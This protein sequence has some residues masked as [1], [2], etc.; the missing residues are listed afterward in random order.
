MSTASNPPHIMDP[1]IDPAIRELVTNSLPPAWQIYTPIILLVLMFGGRTYTAI[2]EKGGVVGILRAFFLGKTHL[3]IAL[4]ALL[5]LSS[6]GALSKLGESPV[7]R[8]VVSTSG[9]FLTA[10]AQEAEPVV[11]EEAIIQAEA[12]RAAVLLQ[13]ATTLQGILVKAAEAAVWTT[14]INMAQARYKKLT[15]RQFYPDKR[16]VLVNP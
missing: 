11:I 10:A 12:R 15:G 6:C 2:S 4:L 7:G 8:V 14:S 1:L 5:A 13:P 9:D 16:P 3:W